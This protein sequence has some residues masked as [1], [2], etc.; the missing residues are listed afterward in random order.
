MLPTA[1]ERIVRTYALEMERFE[2]EREEQMYR[3]FGGC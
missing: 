3:L 1:I 2:V